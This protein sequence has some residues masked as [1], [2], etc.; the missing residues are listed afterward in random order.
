MYIWSDLCFCLFLLFALLLFLLFV[1]D[2][3]EM[4]QVSPSESSL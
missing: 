1:W 4:V 3:I 2:S